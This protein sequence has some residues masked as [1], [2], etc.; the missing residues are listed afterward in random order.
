MVFI[1]QLNV[2]RVGES[3]IDNSSAYHMDDEHTLKAH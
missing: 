2:A 3:R 1:L